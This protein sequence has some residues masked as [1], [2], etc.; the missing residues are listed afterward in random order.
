MGQV[1]HVLGPR[2]CARSAGR[3]GRAGR[4]GGDR[5]C[6]RRYRRQSGANPEG[7]RLLLDRHGVTNA[8]VEY[9]WAD[10]ILDVTEDVPFH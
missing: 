9:N 2:C 5:G 1:P 3:L 8:G 6:E 4:G 10:G 7:G